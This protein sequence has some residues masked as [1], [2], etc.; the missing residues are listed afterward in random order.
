MQGALRAWAAII[1]AATLVLPGCAAQGPTYVDAQNTYSQGELRGLLEG[2]DD[3]RLADTPTTAAGE[4]RT[5]AL[6]ALRGEGST[7]DAAAT[8]VTTVFPPDTMG[9]P[10]YVEWAEVDGARSLILIEAI[11]P[12]EGNLADL[13]LW[14]LSPEGTVRYSE[15]R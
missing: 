13:R 2:A 5:S 11:G 8:L 7:A 1:V 15:T 14:V 4:A 12:R 9:V 3:L 10:V 6:A